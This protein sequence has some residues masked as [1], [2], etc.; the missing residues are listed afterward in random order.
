MNGLFF[1]V[2]VL[3][4]LLVLSLWRFFFLV[5]QRRILAGL[6]WSLQGLVLTLGFFLVLLVLSNLYGYQR[7][8]HEA[9]IADVFMQQLAP[10]QYRVSLSLSHE[11]GDQLEFILNGD[12][13]QLDARILKWK[14]WANLLGL[15]SFYQLERISG[16]YQDIDQARRL[17]PSV[18]DL[19]QP[20]R[21]LDI[22]RMKQLL[23]DK[24]AFVDAL[25]G[26]GVYMPMVDGAHYQVS[27]GQQGLLVRPANDAAREVQP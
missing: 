19:R 1:I 11:E 2:T 12:Q 27:I 25:F 14:G 13:W 15:D 22:F 9:P 6:A 17:Q 3:A 10:Q 26:Q 20:V 7:L 21:G 8:T 16:R 4:V 23:R 18:H 24:L 5:R